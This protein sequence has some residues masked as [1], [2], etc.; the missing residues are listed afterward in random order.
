[1]KNTPKFNGRV[2]Q[3]ALGKPNQTDHITLFKVSSAKVQPAASYPNRRALLEALIGYLKDGS[4]V[5]NQDI[6]SAVTKNEYAAYRA[7]LRAI[8]PSHRK[9]RGGGVDGVKHYLALLGKADRLHGRAENS[10]IPMLGSKSVRRRSLYE[11]A[12]SAYD[13]A[14]EALGELVS[15]NP[16]AA[17]FFDRPVTFT[18]DRYPTLD[19]DSM[20]R[21]NNSD[22]RF[23]LRFENSKESPIY[24]LKLASLQASLAELHGGG[25]AE[26]PTYH[27]AVADEDFDNDLLAPRAA[28]FDP[29]MLDDDFL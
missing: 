4:G 27:S 29:A 25:G 17:S 18:L 26:P 16:G 5:S 20:P 28:S 3:A 12:E 11:Q 1:M 19:P 13:V 10:S 6:R 14:L 24:R 22:S 8:Q 21:L 23:A 7:E 15:M 2:K 9:A